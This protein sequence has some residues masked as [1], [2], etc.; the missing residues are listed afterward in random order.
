MQRKAIADILD[1]REMNVK[2]HYPEHRLSPHKKIVEFTPIFSNSYQA[3]AHEA[4]G[5]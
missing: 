4:Y 3:F 1:Q 5:L 2:S